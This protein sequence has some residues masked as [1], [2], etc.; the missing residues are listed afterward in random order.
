MTCFFDEKF[1]NFVINYIE[2]LKCQGP[3]W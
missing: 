2:F 3:Y 1:I